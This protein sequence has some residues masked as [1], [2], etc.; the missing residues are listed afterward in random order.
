M[1]AP[2]PDISLRDQQAVRGHLLAG[3]TTHSV[4]HALKG[5]VK[6]KRSGI[7]TYSARLTKHIKAAEGNPL[8]KRAMDVHFAEQD[9]FADLRDTIDHVDLSGQPFDLVREVRDLDDK[10]SEAANFLHRKDYSDARSNFL[11]VLDA[12][13]ALQDYGATS[14]DTKTLRMQLDN[15]LPPPRVEEVDQLENEPEEEK[16]PE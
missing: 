15:V 11:E 5:A 8:A 6:G 7:E 1:K 13:D 14:P 10:L 12:L 4:Y 9:L 2:A 3:G 16:A